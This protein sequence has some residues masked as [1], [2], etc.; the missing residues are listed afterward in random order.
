MRFI[1]REV[2]ALRMVLIWNQ[3]SR[4]IWNQEI[5]GRISPP[6]LPVQLNRWR[7]TPFVSKSATAVQESTLQRPPEDSRGFELRDWTCICLFVF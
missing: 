3:A 2:V 5:R 4:Q 1:K 6:S 7:C